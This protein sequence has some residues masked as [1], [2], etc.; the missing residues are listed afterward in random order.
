MRMVT[1]APAAVRVSAP[2][3]AR[4]VIGAA[5]ISIGGALF[6]TH[7]NPRRFRIHPLPYVSDA[8][9]YD[10][11]RILLSFGL[12]FSAAV[13]VPF[14]L[15]LRAQQRADASRL[16][17]TRADS[18]SFIGS[19]AALVLAIGLAAMAAIPGWNLGHHVT[20]A[21]FAV[22]AAVWCLSV[23]RVAHLLPE[24][25]APMAKKPRLPRWVAIVYILGSLL[26]AIIVLFVIV[27]GSVI[28]GWPWKMVANKD[29]RFVV[30][31]ILEYI[32]ASAFLAVV[33]S[34]GTKPLGQHHVVFGL[35][36][37]D[38]HREPSPSQSVRSAVIQGNSK[39]GDAV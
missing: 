34:V 19:I 7:S 35:A 2:L 11:E 22:A 32:G 25:R 33:H 37:A 29:K 27:W 15:A 6:L 23:A 18:V 3:L 5:T 10:P 13:F 8:G 12:S 9:L 28:K 20:A 17:C 4:I 30:L 38:K 1:P 21:I 16:G 14:A 26:A 36:H 31:A 24:A 39:V